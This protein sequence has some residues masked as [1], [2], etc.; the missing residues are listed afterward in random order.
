MKLV[1]KKCPDPMGRGKP[2]AHWSIHASKFV[3]FWTGWFDYDRKNFGTPIEVN[4]HTAH[5]YYLIRPFSK[6]QAYDWDQAKWADPDD[7]SNW[8]HVVVS[9]QRTEIWE[10]IHE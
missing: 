9:P 10:G 3:I 2:H 8:R 7:K 4:L 6:A 1:R 5:K